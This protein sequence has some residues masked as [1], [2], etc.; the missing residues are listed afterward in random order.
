M[1][2][3]QDLLFD[4][5]ANQPAV[6]GIVL[7][8]AGALYGLLGFRMLRFLLTLSCGAIGAVGGVVT[9]RLLGQPEGWCMAAAASALGG[10]ALL[11]RTPAMVL[12]SGAVWAVLGTHVATQCM[13]RG[14]VLWVVMG[15]CGCAGLVLAL[16]SRKAMAVVVTTIQGAGLMIVGFVGVVST[17]IPT[18]GSTFRVCARN[19]SFL[20]P[21]LLLM[22][23]TTLYSCQARSHQGDIRTGV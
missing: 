3:L 7:F 13:M 16:L 1:S 21:V 4:W 19:Q 23:A 5:V 6:T 9:A 18:F 2:R 12:T 15:G 17:I 22:V 14:P 11:W 10:L 20:V 8:L